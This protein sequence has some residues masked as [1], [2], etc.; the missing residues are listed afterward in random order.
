VGVDNWARVK[1]G[2][3]SSHRDAEAVGET[4]RRTSD[5][6]RAAIS[7]GAWADNNSERSKAKYQIKACMVGIGVAIGGRGA[8][9][10]GRAQR[11]IAVLSKP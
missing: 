3:L 9:M 11:Q 4:L 10:G 1:N 2:A 5:E 8:A 6:R 7:C